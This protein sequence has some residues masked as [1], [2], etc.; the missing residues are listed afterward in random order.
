MTRLLL[1]FVTLAALAG[2][3]IFWWLEREPEPAGARPAAAAR[4]VAVETVAVQTR[5]LVRELFLTGSLEAS[6]RIEVMPRLGGRIERIPVEIGDTVVPGDLLLQLD[7]EEFQQD[8][9]Q[10]EAE[11]AVAQAG[12]GEARESLNAARRELTRV[13]ELHGQGIASAAELEAAQTQVALQQTRVEL[14]QSQLRS[15]EAAR[16]STQIRAEFTRVRA[17]WENGLPRHVAERLADPG[18]LVAANT[19]VLTLVALDPLRAVVF[20]TEADYGRLRAGQPV[21]LRTAAWP[22][23]TF[24]G[25]VTRI[26]PEFRE[27]SRQARVEIEVPNPELQLRPGM[28]A[29]I[30]IELERRLG[31]QSVPRDALLQREEGFVLFTVDPATDPPQARRHRVTPG[32]RDGDWVEI[33]EPELSGA[34]VTLGQ[35]LLSEDTP[36]RLQGAGGTAPRGKPDAAPGR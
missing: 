6:R 2:A 28:F 20:V 14:A 27:A 23:E 12:L 11:F 30:A 33:V 24:T 1:A 9:L 19:P 3:G 10:A 22:G 21:R 29:E 7:P 5:D 18:A 13:R 8:L 17:D 4:P 16:R 32:I 35:H 34:V 31:A 25:R 36:V 15:R 26:A